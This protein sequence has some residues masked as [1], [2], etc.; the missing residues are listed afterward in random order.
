MSTLPSRQCEKPDAAVVK[1]SAVCTLALATA[2]GMP[3][4]IS[5]V[6]QVTP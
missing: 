3:S 6:E 5:A 4:E 1:I 2:G